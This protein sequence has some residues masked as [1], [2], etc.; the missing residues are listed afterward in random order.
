MT[1]AFDE[2][3]DAPCLAAALGRLRELDEPL[4]ELD[5]LL[6]AFDVLA[7]EFVDFARE[8]DDFGR[9]LDVF[10]R[11]PDE[12]LFAVLRLEPLPFVAL[13]PFELRL[14]VLR[15][16]PDRELDWAISPP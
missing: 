15:L 2:P 16:V 11:E 12:E 4:P 1:A 7:R 10:A 5:A 14:P 9:E 13:D 3:F 6:R 8:L